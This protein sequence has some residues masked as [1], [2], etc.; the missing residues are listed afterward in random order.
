MYTLRCL[1]GLIVWTSTL[2]IIFCFAAIGIIFLYNAGVITSSYATTLGIPTIS[3]GTQS[4]YQ[5]IGYTCVGIAGVLLL[6]FICCCSRIRLAVAVCK[7]AGQ[8]VAHTCSIILVPILQTAIVLAMW[9]VCIVAMLY[10]ISCTT[11]VG[12]SSS[13]FTSVESYTSTNLNQFY[14]FVFGTLWCNAFIQAAGTFVV[15]SSC[16]IWYYSHGPD[17]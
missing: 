1:A 17:Q 16:C 4:E 9:A 3:G 6:T 14:T 2:G 8:F 15:A 5:A 13:V 11:F 7:A 10:I 12:S